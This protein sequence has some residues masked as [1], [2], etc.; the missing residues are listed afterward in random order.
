MK[1]SGCTLK[2]HRTSSQSDICLTQWH[3]NLQVCKNFA[4]SK[5]IPMVAVWSNGQ[6]CGHCNT[7]ASAVTESTFTDFQKK[8]K[9]VW[10]FLE[11]SDSDAKANSKPYQWCLG[12]AV[13]DRETPYIRTVT[14]M[15]KGH[16]T[17]KS[18][19]GLPFYPFVNLYWKVN[20][21]IVI[22]K[23][24]TGDTVDGGLG[25]KKGATNCVNNIKK[26]FKSVF[27]KYNYNP[28]A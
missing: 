21:K 16:A 23:L 3:T 20:G 27:S 28:N 12:D 2:R 6:A 10:C 18:E 14:Y 7:F 17:R 19:I 25:G 15:N 1:Y 22:D 11:S 24:Y 8:Y 5:G 4:M 26:W 9:V 13:Y